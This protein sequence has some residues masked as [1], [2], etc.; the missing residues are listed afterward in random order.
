MQ[1][2]GKIFLILDARA[3]TPVSYG[4]FHITCWIISILIGL[5]LCKKFKDPDEKTVRKILFAMGV[6]CVLLEI[7]KQ[8]VYSFSYSEGKFTFDYQWYAFPFQFCSTP[9][10]IGL[11]AGILS[12]VPYF[13]F[14]TGLVLSVFLALMQNFTMGQ[15]GGLAAIFI[16]GQVLESYILTPYLVGDKVGLHPVWIIF[17]LLEH[18]CI[19]FAKRWHF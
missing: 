13:G 15:W 6:I 11:L 10:Y 5:W 1:L 17:A 16:V 3:Q 7:Y 4:W 9:M 2:L 19:M 14:G 18:F 8:T 12:F